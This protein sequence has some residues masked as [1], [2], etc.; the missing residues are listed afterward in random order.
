[1]K[2]KEYIDKKFKERYGVKFK[3]WLVGQLVND[4]DLTVIKNKNDILS[5]AQIEEAKL[6]LEIYERD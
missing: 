3:S 2:P 1:M 6:L 4:L 5:S